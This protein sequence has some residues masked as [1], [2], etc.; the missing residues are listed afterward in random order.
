M[1]TI[2]IECYEIFYEEVFPCDQC[3]SEMIM[4]FEDWDEITRKE[5]ELKKAVEL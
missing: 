5:T 2:C 3:N 4:S 1:K